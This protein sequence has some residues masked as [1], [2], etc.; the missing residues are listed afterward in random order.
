M[1]K[2]LFDKNVSNELINRI[3]QLKPNQTPLWGKMSVDKMLA[4]CNVAYSYTYQPEKFKKPSA[5]KKF[6]LKIFVKNIVVSE[7]SY[8]KNGRT[9]PEFVI[10]ESKDF[11][12]EKAKLIE[13]INKTQQLGA[14]YFNGLENFSFGKMTDKEWNNLFYKHLNHHLTQF[15]V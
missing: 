6:M 7:K 1:I 11:E 3:E 13:N 2:N 10:A 8:T 12:K 15:G 5:F 4:H 14:S 9:A